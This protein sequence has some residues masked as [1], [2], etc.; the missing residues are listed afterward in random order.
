MRLEAHAAAAPQPDGTDNA[1]ASL[2]LPVTLQE[3][4]GPVAT[5]EQQ[6]GA[7]ATQC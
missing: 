2:S 3:A 6:V 7:W 4:E 5:A 1:T